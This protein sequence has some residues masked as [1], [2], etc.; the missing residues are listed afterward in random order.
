M[1]RSTYLVT[2][3]D[4]LGY[5][6]AWGFWLGLLF[7]PVIIGIFILAPTFAQN[8][9]P[10]RYFAVIEQGDTFTKALRQQMD[11]SVG[12]MARAM[13]DPL[14][15][16]EDRESEKIAAFDEARANG[17]SVDEAFAQAGGNTAMLPRQDFVE[18]EAP[19]SNSAEL[20][21]YLIGETLVDTD[22]GP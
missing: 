18:V 11:D 21:P 9:Q 1:I 20:A 12:V 19:V 14:A 5:V 15:I 2:M 16:A 7:T 4:Y 3:R 22:E 13:L 10:T 8:A 17:A 6:S